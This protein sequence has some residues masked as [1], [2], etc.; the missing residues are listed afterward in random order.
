MYSNKAAASEMP[1]RTCFVR[2]SVE[3]SDNA[4][5]RGVLAR[6]DR[7][8]EIRWAFSQARE[9]HGRPCTVVGGRPWSALRTPELQ[10][11]CCGPNDPREARS[12]EFPVVGDVVNPG[13]LCSSRHGGYSSIPGCYPVGLWCHHGTASGVPVSTTDEKPALATA[14]LTGQVESRRPYPPSSLREVIGRPG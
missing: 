9:W 11:S 6:R 4:A 8:G 10:L 3:R 7:V 2:R 13:H 12:C 5:V 1:S 14:G